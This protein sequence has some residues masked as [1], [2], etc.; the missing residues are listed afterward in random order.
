MCPDCFG[1]QKSWFPYLGREWGA[2]GWLRAYL[3]PWRLR[4]QEKFWRGGEHKEWLLFAVDSPVTAGEPS[5]GPK[6]HLSCEL[7]SKP[8]P[9][10]RMGLEATEGCQASSPLG[11]KYALSLER[12]GASSFHWALLTKLEFDLCCP[13]SFSMWLFGD[14]A[15]T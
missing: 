14:R 12:L 3:V 7:N 13:N 6:S 5:G 1:F 8:T 11:R 10:D 15:P 9:L 4:S 2:L